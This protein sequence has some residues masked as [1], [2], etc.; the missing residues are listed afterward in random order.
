MEYEEQAE[1]LVVWAIGEMHGCNCQGI[2]GEDPD[3][4]ADHQVFNGIVEPTQNQRE[5]CRR[6]PRQVSMIA[7]SESQSW[8]RG[9]YR[10][11]PGSRGPTIKWN[12]TIHRVKAAVAKVNGHDV[13]PRKKAVERSTST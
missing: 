9:S 3:K 13:R 8:I 7:T 2:P 4:A 11:G 1:A 5:R 6:A 10:V 12:A